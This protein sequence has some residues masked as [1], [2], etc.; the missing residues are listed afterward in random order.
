MTAR[1]DWPK[2]DLL[3]QRRLELGWPS[4][5]PAVE[6]LPLLLLKGAVLGVA[7]L[8]I[9]IASVLFFENQQRHLEDEVLELASVEARVGGIQAKLRTMTNERVA[10]KQQTDRI[11]AQLVALR[12]GSALLAQMQ[13]VTPQGVRMLSLA[14]LPSK[15]VIRGE[16]EGVD[17]YA[18]IN[19]FALNLE[20]LADLLPAGTNVLKARSNDDG[21]IEFSLEAA[22]DPSAKVTPERL[23]ELG[24][25]GLA[26]RYELLRAK[27]M[28]Q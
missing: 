14:A 5:P 20:A 8:V 12:S 21:L 25:E 13:Q 18:R 16:A 19:A 23:R 22:L 1:R 26:R 2:P 11:A 15:L 17:A 27:G 24:S 28:A 3:Q 9:P 4:Q 10:L 7:V 6:P